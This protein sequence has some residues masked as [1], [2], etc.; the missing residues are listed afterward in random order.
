MSFQG[1]YTI[2]TTF[3][4]PGDIINGGF[5]LES[6]SSV[7]SVGRVN[8]LLHISISSSLRFPL[9]NKCSL[10]QGGRLVTCSGKLFHFFKT[11]PLY[12]TPYANENTSL[13]IRK[14][15]NPYLPITENFCVHRFA[16][17]PHTEL[18]ILLLKQSAPFNQQITVPNDNIN[19]KVIW[20]FEVSFSQILCIFTVYPWEKS[21]IQW[22]KKKKVAFMQSKH[23][24][25]FLNES[26]ASAL[27]NMLICDCQ[28]FIYQLTLF[29]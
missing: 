13:M 16:D 4:S 7:F 5:T 21:P 29:Q 25:I 22:L 3:L 15:W 19:S 11:Q 9:P 17:Q 27:M 8:F 10:S 1:Q 2:H 23:F 20:L 18:P 28:S 24:T 12:F 14:R 26:K 6:K